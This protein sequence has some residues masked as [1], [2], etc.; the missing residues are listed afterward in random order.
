MHGYKKNNHHFLLGGGITAESCGW[1]FVDNVP[2][3]Y[4]RRRVARQLQVETWL[5]LMQ[6]VKE[7]KIEDLNLRKRDEQ[8]AA[9]YIA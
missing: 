7:L 4:D 6:L 3:L 2:L 8:S 5:S 9:S 1:V